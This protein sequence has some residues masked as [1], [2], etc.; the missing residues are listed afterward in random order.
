[1]GNIIKFLFIAAFPMCSAW[2]LS[3]MDIFGEES[4]PK[5]LSLSL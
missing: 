4:K 1:M 3:N 2:K 5:L